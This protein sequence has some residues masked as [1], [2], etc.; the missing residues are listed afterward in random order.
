MSNYTSHILHRRRNQTQFS[1]LGEN[2]SFFAICT[3]RDLMCRSSYAVWIGTMERSSLCPANG[4]T[5]C[6]ISI[7]LWLYSTLLDLGSFF[8][9]LI[10][11][12]SVGLLGWAI[13]RSQGRCL[14]TQQHK[15]RI[16][17]HRHPCLELDSSP[18]SQR[19]SGRRQFMP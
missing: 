13:I 18:Q 9:F 19:S 7:Y 15:H 3:T 12:Q 11:T 16:N 8:S 10:Y 1:G 4:S 17:A 2:K 14:H 6:L 5:I